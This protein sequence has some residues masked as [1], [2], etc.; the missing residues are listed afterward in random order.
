MFQS[1]V[2][3]GERVY[4]AHP[5]GS[6][7]TVDVPV[8][9]PGGG[10]S[11]RDRAVSAIPAGRGD[12]AGPGRRNRRAGATNRAKATRSARGRT[13]TSG[14]DPTTGTRL[15]LPGRPDPT[16]T[17]AR[18][19]LGVTAGPLPVDVDRAL[20]RCVSTG[21]ARWASEVLQISQWRRAVTT[22]PA[23]PDLAV[24]LH[25]RP[26]GL[27]TRP[28]L[29]PWPGDG[30]H[31]AAAIVD[32]MTARGRLIAALQAAQYADTAALA[33]DYPGL[34]D[35]LGMELSM[36]LH[37]TGP[38][39]DTLIATAT[40]LTDRLPHTLAA[41]A[42]GTIT[43]TV[44]RTMVRATSTAR[45]AVA[46]AVDADVTP[47]TVTNGWN[48]EQVRRRAHR[49][50]IAHDPDGAAQRHHQARRDRYMALSLI[51]ISEPT[52]RTP[53]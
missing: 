50:I 8:L 27:G 17:A 7:A 23:G 28:G 45:P 35:M 16:L 40:A 11:T 2:A 13:S 49:Q 37:L 18:A 24:A 30:V 39:A 47:D 33:K 25:A 20:T 9:L 6:T 4:L 26:D 41:L 14:T 51:H 1:G 42:E 19:T 15:V 48:P 12:T 10:A 53:I 29:R 21:E 22:L 34:T 31:W 46:R 36:A 38:A 52:R 5:H 32:G 44:A 3:F 43:D